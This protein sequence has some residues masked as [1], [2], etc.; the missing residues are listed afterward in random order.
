M[1]KMDWADNRGQQNG[2]KSRR[3]G[4]R[5]TH[6]HEPSRPEAATFS[7]VVSEEDSANAVTIF[8]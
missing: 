6:L 7:T 8:R 2:F 5:A 4:E 1:N 3:D